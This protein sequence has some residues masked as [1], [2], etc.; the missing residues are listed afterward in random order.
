MI[1][2]ELLIEIFHKQ[3][4]LLGSEKGLSDIEKERIVR[5][6]IK[7]KRS[8]FMDERRIYPALTGKEIK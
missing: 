4:D 6:F 2:E 8:P 3:V 1:S 7:A 5:T